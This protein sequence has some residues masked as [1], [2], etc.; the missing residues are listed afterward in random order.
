MLERFH[1]IVFELE[2]EVQEESDKITE[3]LRVKSH[4]RFQIRKKSYNYL[5]DYNKDEIKIYK[6][7]N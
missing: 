5:I 6:D 7:K 2:K 4:P 3:Y 1:E